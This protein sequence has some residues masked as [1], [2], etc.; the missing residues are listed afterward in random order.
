MD[1]GDC[2][3]IKSGVK[4]PEFNTYDM[5]GWQGRILS[6]IVGNGFIE[7]FF[8]SITLGQLPTEF[9]ESGCDS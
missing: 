4:D 9:I 8:D 7:I 2:V 1:F 3:R 5:G 6:D